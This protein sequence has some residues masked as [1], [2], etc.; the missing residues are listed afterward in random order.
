MGSLSSVL[1]L[2]KDV[3]KF[4]LCQACLAVSAR[5]LFRQLLHVKT[6]HPGASINNCLGFVGLTKGFF[7]PLSLLS[8]Q[9]QL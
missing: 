5:S 8:F 3:H 1:P 4:I 9:N 6:R 7:S 2:L